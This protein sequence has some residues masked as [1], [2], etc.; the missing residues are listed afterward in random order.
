MAA[1]KAKKTTKYELTRADITSALQDV[2]ARLEDFNMYE[3]TI[4]DIETMLSDVLS[5]LSGLSDDV[6]TK[7]Y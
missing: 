7:A 2:C 1:K 4:N 3:S 5:E 6:N